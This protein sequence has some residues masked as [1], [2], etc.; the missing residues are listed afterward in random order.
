MVHLDETLGG[1]IPIEKLWDYDAYGERMRRM[2]AEHREQLEAG[3]GSAA[4]PAA[5]AAPAALSALS[6]EDSARQVPEEEEDDDKDE[7][8]DAGSHIAESEA[9]EEPE[10][11]EQ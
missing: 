11:K 2:D 4:A 8:D 9:A 6:L 1:E 3:G 5:P 10:G 7:F